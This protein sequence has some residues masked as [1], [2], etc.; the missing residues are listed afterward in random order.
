M[1]TFKVGCDPELFLQQDRHIISAVPYIDGTKQSPTKLTCG[2]TLQRDNVALEFATPPVIGKSAFINSIKITLDEI[3]GLLPNNLSLLATP[4]AHLDKKYLR[5]PE[6]RKFGCDPDWNCWT[7]SLNEMSSKAAE[8]TLRSCG[9]HPHISHPA[10][11]IWENKIDYACLMD[12]FA[13]Q[14]SVLLDSSEEGKKRKTLYGKAGAFRPNKYP[15]GDHGVEYRVLSNFWIKSPKLVELIYNFMEDSLN[16]TINNKL[17]E[18]LTLVDPG[19][20]IDNINNGV[21]KEVKKSLQKLNK[22]LSTK[23]KA[24]LVQCLK[25]NFNFEEEWR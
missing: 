14:S 25:T 15:C 16:M 24:L 10:L 23:T 13:G 4:S 19:E 22:Y 2:S 5:H 20:V 21:V 1:E 9:A 3:R 6:A 8:G 18:V 11:E 12:I 7:E 17:D